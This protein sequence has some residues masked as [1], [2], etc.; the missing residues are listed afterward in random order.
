MTTDLT[1]P[2]SQRLHTVSD[3]INMGEKIAWGSETALMDEAAAALDATMQREAKLLAENE[4]L[5]QELQRW[6][7][8][9]R[10]NTGNNSDHPEQPPH[11]GKEVV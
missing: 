3:M 6:H 10:M 1:N 7:F 11:T 9:S 5:R 4:Q 2:L 8:N